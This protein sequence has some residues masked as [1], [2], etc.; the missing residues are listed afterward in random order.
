MRVVVY[1]CFM[2]FFLCICEIHAGGKSRKYVKKT[3]SNC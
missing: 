2:S 1:V 3:D